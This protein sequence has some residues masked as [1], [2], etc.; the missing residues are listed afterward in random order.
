M[1]F[2]I[3]TSLIA[4]AFSV[5]GINAQKIN[6]QK[7]TLEWIGKKIGGQH[8][9]KIQ[10]NSGEIKLANNKIESGSF[11]IDMNTITCTDLKD[12]GYN[13]KLVG[14]LK[15][16]DFFGVD[17]YPTANFKVTKS[18]SFKNGKATLTGNLTIKGIT[19]KISFEVTKIKNV[20]TANLDIDRSKYN[21]RYGS[22]SFF[23]SLGDA[24]ID[25]IFKLNIKLIT[26][27]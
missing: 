23:D 10:L 19:Q 26:N 16:D 12:D 1:K 6:I 20:F 9:G 3:Y 15:S 5:F 8:N 21:V 24:A 7:S 2:K 22:N 13:Q 11:Y 14:H 25:D 4:L 17:K 18:T 27:K